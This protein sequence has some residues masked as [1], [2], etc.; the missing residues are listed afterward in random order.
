[1]T[2]ITQLLGRKATPAEVASRKKKVQDIINANLDIKRAVD[3]AVGA[4]RPKTEKQ[5][6]I[7]RIKA[8]E[9]AMKNNSS[10]SDL[11]TKALKRK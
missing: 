6:E 7:A 4:R 1:M 11:I 8:I 9:K 10:I 5:L 2:I 3:Q